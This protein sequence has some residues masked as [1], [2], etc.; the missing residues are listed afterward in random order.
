M[1]RKWIYGLVFFAGSALVAADAQAQASGALYIE[2]NASSGNTI[3]KFDRYDDGS[4]VPSGEFVTGGQGTG[5]GLGNQG[6]LLLTKGER[7]LLAVNGGSNDI[8]VLAVEENGLRLVDRKPSGG[9]HPISI[10]EDHGVVY[11]L[12]N[13]SAAGGTDNISG[14]RISNKGYLSSISGSTRPLSA[15]AVGPAQI[16]F[17]EEGENLIV[18]EKGTNTI[19]VY[20]VNDYGIAGN[21]TSY[22]SNA[23]TPFGF[24]LGKRGQIFVTDAAG[25]APNASAVSA[26]EL[27]DSGLHAIG[28]ASATHQTSACWAAVTHD[29]RF[30]YSANTG[31]NTIT[32]FRIANDGTLSLLNADGNAAPADGA[33]ADLALSNGDRFLYVVNG[34]THSITAY[35]V[36]QD[37][38]LDPLAGFSGL[39]VGT[40]GLAVR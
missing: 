7:F 25:G 36:N 35:Q 39:P 11:V 24:A 33:P 18:T 31:G 22:A 26:Y 38:S 9:L 10:T 28:G 3:L 30:V 6:G 2:S 12:N 17:D 16:Q 14:F 27:S 32:A 40:T 20:R 13:G 37:G 5:A 23:V 29:G 15:P 34:A 1:G 21:P 8:S 19:D 4:L